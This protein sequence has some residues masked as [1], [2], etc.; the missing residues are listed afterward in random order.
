MSGK[1]QTAP[2]VTSVVFAL[3][4]DHGN[5]PMLCCCTFDRA[6]V[7]DDESALVSIRRT[8]LQPVRKY[9]CALRADVG[10]VVRCMKAC[11]H[12]GSRA[13]TRRVRDQCTCS[14]LSLSRSI[15]TPMRFSEARTRSARAV[16]RSRGRRA[17][18]DILFVTFG[19]LSGHLSLRDS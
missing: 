14:F 13:C 4:F 9:S 10:V 8:S 12:A 5:S 6:G 18:R 19:R 16:A 17:T 2:M 7:C 15:D 1:C 3:G 11:V